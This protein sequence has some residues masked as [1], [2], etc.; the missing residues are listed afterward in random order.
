MT[1]VMMQES[2]RPSR[3]KVL[4]LLAIAKEAEP[5]EEAVCQS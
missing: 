1:V 2:S 5:L 4:V 3:K